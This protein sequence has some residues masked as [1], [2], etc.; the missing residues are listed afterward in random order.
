MDYALIAGAVDFTAVL[1][2]LGLVAIAIAGIKVAK[3][4]AGMLL[5]FIGR[6]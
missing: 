5:S 4:G 3:R 1:A 2:G 6:G